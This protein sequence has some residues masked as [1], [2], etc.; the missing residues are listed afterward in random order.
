MDPAHA[1]I[2]LL[3][4]GLSRLYSVKG[5]HIEYKDNK[6]GILGTAKYCSL[7][8]H[9]GID[10]SRRDDLDQIMYSLIFFANDGNLPWSG[11]DGP[12]K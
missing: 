12:N 8:T 2:L 9:Y 10:Q 5:E 3:D 4:F 7:N 11:C 1:D 6:R